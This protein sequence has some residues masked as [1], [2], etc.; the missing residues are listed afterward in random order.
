MTAFKS[1]M[2]IKTLLPISSGSC[3]SAPSVLTCPSP[4]ERASQAEPLKV[5]A[6]FSPS[7]CLLPPENMRMSMTWLCAVDGHGEHIYWMSVMKWVKLAMG[8]SDT[9]EWALIC[10]GK[11]RN[12]L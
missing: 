5:Q 3:G 8:W 1:F 9:N 2:M 7:P 10:T 11:Y 6:M 12:H 4:F